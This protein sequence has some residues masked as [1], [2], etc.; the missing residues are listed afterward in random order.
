MDVEQKRELARLSRE[1]SFA[2]LAN[3]ARRGA[4]LA[5]QFT[6]LEVQ[7]ATILFAFAGLFLQSFTDPN[8]FARLSYAAVLWVKISYATS[9]F[10]LVLSLVMGLLHIKRKEKFWD[11]SMGGFLSLF[12]SWNGV[13]R[14]EKSY[15][16]GR[17]FHQGL[18]QGEEGIIR[19]PMWTWV[20]QTIFLG[21]AVV[22]LFVLALVFLFK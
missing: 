15:E 21:I 19:S 5:D 4:E 3:S 2:G 20:L 10:F 9:L 18:A 16:D 14:K 22:L 13:L 6:G 17:S 8:T 11:D 12:K 1:T 7:I